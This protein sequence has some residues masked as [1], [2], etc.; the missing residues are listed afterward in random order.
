[1][2]VDI[3]YKELVYL[4]RHVNKTGHNQAPSME[5]AKKPKTPGDDTGSDSSLDSDPEVDV[6]E[7]PCIELNVGRIIR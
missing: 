3:N 4:R 7:E 6:D 2:N 5:C 1:M